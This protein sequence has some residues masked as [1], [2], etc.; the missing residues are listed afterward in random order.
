MILFLCFTLGMNAQ[1][2]TVLDEY[3]KPLEF[4]ELKSKSAQKT[5][6]TSEL[7]KTDVSSF[8]D[9]NDIQ[10]GLAG[11]KK[12]LL[13][14]ADL[15]AINFTVI[16]VKEVLDMDEL[17]VSA[18]RWKQSKRD[19]PNRIS[20]LDMEH[21]ELQNPQTAADLLESSGEVFVQK[22]Q[23]GGGSPMIRGFATN[24]LLYT[25]DG[26]RMN[27]AIF[28][29]GNIQNVISLD[30]FVMENTEVFFGPGGVIYGSDAIGGVMSFS[31]LTPQFAEEEEDLYKRGKFVGRYSSANNEKTGHFDLNF[32]WE[33]F[34]VLTSF[35][36][37]DYGNLRMGNNNGPD[38]YLKPFVVVRENN[39]DVVVENADPLVQDPTAYSQFNIMQKLRYSPNSAWDINYSFHY[40]E[41]SDYDRFDRL[42]EVDENGLPRS[43]VWKYGPQIWMMNNVNITH[44]NTKNRMYDFASL[45]LAHQFFRESRIDRRFNHFRLRNQLEEV[46]ALSVNLD[47][48]KSFN[49]SNLFYGLEGVRNEVI[50]KGTAIDIV[51]SE[52]IFVRNRYPDADW[53]TLSVYANYQYQLTEKMML[54]SGVRYTNFFV[55]AD[56][57]NHQ[58]LF[59]YLEASENWRNDAVTGSL[60]WVYNWNKKS[61]IS[62]NVSSGFRAPNVDDVGK[63]FDFTAD[64]L[65]VPNIALGA[66]YAYNAELNFSKIF[67][68]FLKFDGSM[69]YTFLKNAIVRRPY[70]VEGFSTLEMEGQVYNVFAL[71]NAAFGEVYGVNAA[72]EI[73]LAKNLRLTTTFNYQLG[74]EEMED[75]STSRSRHAAPWFGIT[76]LRYNY[77]SFDIQVYTMYSGEIT[78]ENLNL[79]ETF[80]PFIYPTDENGN[81]Y[82]PGWYTLNVKMRYTITKHFSATL[83]VENLTDQRYRTYSSGIA[84]NGL[85]FIIGIIGK[86]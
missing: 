74:E 77:K 67:G 34:A 32:G 75:G 82:S 50:S 48:E 29:G 83:G 33:N 46:L 8:K 18:T 70:E 71:Q 6:Y 78:A 35:S 25:V 56:F 55:Y 9:A 37:N 39:E 4:V 57:T 23:Q 31:T 15:A 12:L 58:S 40:S 53:N 76:R 51:T 42:S 64:N 45:R 66:E 85:N 7:G 44:E 22:S 27:N 2:L 86:I 11:Y 81:L 21:L 26:I 65:T 10:I 14:Y 80:K 30:P 38:D 79:E 19:V 36:Y 73:K 20:S 52:A 54:Q 41:T 47:F 61:H 59:P 5:T 84:A 69:Y 13:S 28:R 49:R 72:I 63:V 1:E 24:R 17:V 16:L 43:A 62:A 60:G 3:K 68:D